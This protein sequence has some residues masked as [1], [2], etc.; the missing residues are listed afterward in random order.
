MRT[1]KRWKLI[2]RANKVLKDKK[3]VLCNTDMWIYVFTHVKAYLMYIINM[4]STV[5]YRLG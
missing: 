5:N 2:T 3:A 1:I 4:N